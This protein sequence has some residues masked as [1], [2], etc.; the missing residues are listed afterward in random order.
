MRFIGRTL[1]AMA[2]PFPGLTGALIDRIW[3][4]P[5]PSGRHP[6]VDARSES[7]DTASGR[8]HAL[9]W[10]PTDAQAPLVVMLHGWGSAASRFHQLAAAIAAR[11]HTV[12]APDL[13]GHGR[14]RS[15]RTNIFQAAQAVEGMTA[16][17]PQRPVAL[18]GHSFGGLTAMYLAATGYPAP[19]LVSVAAP[20]GLDD[21]IGIF[22]RQIAA[23]PRSEALL[24]AKV[25]ERYG[26]ELARTIEMPRM[27]ASYPNPAL[28]VHDE[29]D[30]EVP[31]RAAEDLVAAIPQAELMRT[32]GLGHRRLLKD[33]AVVER[34]A[35][36]VQG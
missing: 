14:S 17:Q 24:R 26:A 19:R 34:I 16:A 3:H 25:A 31:M 18:I 9:R 30:P 15:G 6:E 8:I 21:V 36:F 2:G 1:E 32:R 7:Y 11:G 27:L 12:L 20:A 29:D 10:G 23:G 35:G 22:R 5:Y 33:A 28:I 13:P 4:T